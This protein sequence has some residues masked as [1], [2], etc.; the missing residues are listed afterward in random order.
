MRVAKESNQDLSKG[1]QI[2]NL[3]AKTLINL[4]KACF[5]TRRWEWNFKAHLAFKKKM[6]P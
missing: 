6:S 4:H 1:V 5:L 2:S 3:R